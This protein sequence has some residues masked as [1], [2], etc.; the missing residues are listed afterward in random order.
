M[1]LGKEV[2]HLLKNETFFVSL[3]LLLFLGPMSHLKLKCE[4][5]R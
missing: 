2:K 4:M 3:L 1:L 5:L